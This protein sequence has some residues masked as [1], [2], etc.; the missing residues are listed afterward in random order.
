[1]ILVSQ[2]ELATANRNKIK[3]YDIITTKCLYTLS[4]HT[5]EVRDLKLLND[6]ETLLSGDWDGKLKKWCLKT[7]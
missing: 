5:W 7:K 4:G 6:D 1:M 3:V 2:K